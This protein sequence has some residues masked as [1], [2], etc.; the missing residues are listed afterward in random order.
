MLDGGNAEAAFWLA[1]TVEQVGGEAAQQALP[2]AGSDNK[3]VR[4]AAQFASSI[5]GLGLAGCAVSAACPRTAT[6]SAAAPVA[7]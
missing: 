5:H 2:I 4:L 3:P 1:V 7:S 6:C